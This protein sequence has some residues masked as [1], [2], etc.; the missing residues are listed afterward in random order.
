MTTDLTRIVF[1]AET[2][3]PSHA[4]FCVIFQNAK[5]PLPPATIYAICYD[6]VLQGRRVEVSGEKQW[7]GFTRWQIDERTIEVATSGAIRVMA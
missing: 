2:I 4:K 5:L 3:P 6:R 7:N 1:D